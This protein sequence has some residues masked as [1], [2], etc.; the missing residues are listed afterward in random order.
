L[1]LR[2]L[3]LYFILATTPAIAG[4]AAAAKRGEALVAKGL[5]ALPRDRSYL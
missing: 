5:H 2:L 1:L 4:D 3:G